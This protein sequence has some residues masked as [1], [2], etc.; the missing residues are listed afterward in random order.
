MKEHKPKMNIRVYDDN[1]G[2]IY[3]ANDL[4]FIPRTK[5]IA[6]NITT[7]GVVLRIR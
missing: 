4:K 1:K 2:A 7:S 3:M 6:L 5:H